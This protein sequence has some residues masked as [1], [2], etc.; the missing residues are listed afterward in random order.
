MQT[1]GI[2]RD[3]TTD[4]VNVFNP[5]YVDSPISCYHDSYSDTY[6]IPTYTNEWLSKSGINNLGWRFVDGED[7]LYNGDSQIEV[8]VDSDPSD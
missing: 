7:I 1:R 8:V 6:C 5:S 2:I 3:K 4:I